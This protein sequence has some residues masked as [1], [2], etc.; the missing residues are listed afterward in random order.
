MVNMVNRKC[1]CKRVEP[2]F[3]LEGGKPTHCVKCK[4]SEM[5]NVV[6]PKCHCKKSRPKFGLEGGKPTHCAEC[7]TGE[8]VNV[9]YLK[10]HCKK[11]KVPCFGLEGGKPTHCATCKTTD[12][13]NVV[14]RK[15]HCRRVEPCFGLEGG[16]PTHC[17][18]CKTSQMVDVVN[19]RCHCKKS[20]PNFGLEGGKPTHCATCKT[21][22]MV[23]VVC[24]KCSNG[25]G[26]AVENRNKGYCVRC[27]IFLFPGD[28]LSRNY[29]VKERHFVDHIRAAGVLPSHAEVTFDTK[30]QGGCSL[31]KP[32]IFVD[33]FT[34]T[35]HSENDEDQHRSY[36]CENKRL[37]ELF[38]DAGNRPQVQLRFNPDG[39]TS[40]DGKKHP[41]CF[42]YNNLGVPVIRDQA[43]WEA[44]M[45]T[46]LERLAYHLSHVP[47]REIT[48]ENMCY[49]GFDW[50]DEE[51]V[52]RK[53]KRA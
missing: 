38:Q 40:A 43:M 4:T 15:C 47:D 26:T 53:R 7:K 1:H 19:P 22:E 39:Y 10:C 50:K 14:S 6:N 11:P 46:Y 36:S 31:R 18:V 9:V 52:A 48:I 23:N 24:K 30:L 16:K 12:M 25:C 49:D 5:V 51:R 32:D 8:M 37:M 45:G 20:Q 29:K 28:K 35:V 17:A 2:S 33:V 13:V 34:H 44:R 27:F 3:G 41:S 21:S 42:K